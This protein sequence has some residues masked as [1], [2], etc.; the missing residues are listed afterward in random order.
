MQAE[1]GICGSGGGEWEGRG[2]ER[3]KGH[4]GCI[5][6]GT[7]DCLIEPLC[8]PFAESFAGAILGQ[9]LLRQPRRQ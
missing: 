7:M 3:G 6:V 1:T 5:G 8:Q 4:E 9:H 2:K